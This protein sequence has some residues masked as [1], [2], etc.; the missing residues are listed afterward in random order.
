MN[1][2]DQFR[3]S[4]L[5]FFADFIKKKK[6]SAGTNSEQVQLARQLSSLGPGNRAT[7]RS[8]PLTHYYMVT[9]ISSPSSCV[10]YYVFGS[11]VISLIC[12]PFTTL[13]NS[14]KL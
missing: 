1:Q 7:L 8:I 6:V 9:V 5:E 10:N 14:L 13:I 4:L 11:Y 3:L 12:G 2:K